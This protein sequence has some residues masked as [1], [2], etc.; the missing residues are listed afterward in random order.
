[1]A[2]LGRYPVNMLWVP[3]SWSASPWVMD[4]MT[5]I[6]SAIWAVFGRL[7]LKTSPLSFVGT[8]PRGPRYSMGALGCGSKVSWWAMPPGI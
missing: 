4:R 5:A 2:G 7:A 8:V 6:L 3:R 1:M